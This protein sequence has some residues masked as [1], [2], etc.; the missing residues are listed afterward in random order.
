MKLC[1]FI[2]ILIS[3]IKLLP[4]GEVTDGIQ[5]AVKKFTSVSKE[6]EG[7]KK[8]LSRLERYNLEFQRIHNNEKNDGK[9][10]GGE[11]VTSLVDYSLKI[12]SNLI[13]DRVQASSF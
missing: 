9:E 10:F 5:E 1:Y 7:H 11:Q 12:V 13:N 2:L 8:A 4:A 6:E 3:T